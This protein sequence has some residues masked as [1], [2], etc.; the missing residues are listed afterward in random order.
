LKVGSR[1][2]AAVPAVLRRDELPDSV[3]PPT[4]QTVDLCVYTH[5]RKRPELRWVNFL[6]GLRNET[7][8]PGFHQKHDHNRQKITYRHKRANLAR[9][10]NN[11]YELRYGLGYLGF[12]N[13]NPHK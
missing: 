4:V 10:H 3:V 6:I 2:W 8:P 13:D 11:R 5:G 7:T 9:P 12:A 1:A